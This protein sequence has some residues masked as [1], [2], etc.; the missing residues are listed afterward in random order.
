MI[1][2]KI[3][4]KNGITLTSLIITIIIMLILAGV[5]IS[6]LV[7][8]DGL[9][10]K[11]QEAATNTKIAEIKERVEMKIANLNIEKIPEEE[12][13]TLDDVYM[14]KNKDKE[15]TAAFKEDD[16]VILVVDEYE[17]K[18]GSSLK[19]ETVSKYDSVKLRKIE[20]DLTFCEFKEKEM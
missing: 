2:R 20:R 19:V 17:C 13:V 3:N 6:I 11:A 7:G 14:L 10:G 1:N 16:S 9:I 4:E 18:I 5:S 15:I 12:K 8:P